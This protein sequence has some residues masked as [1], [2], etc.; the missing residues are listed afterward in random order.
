LVKNG[1]RGSSPNCI[2]SQYIV[3]VSQFSANHGS[4]RPVERLLTPLRRF[5]HVES[6]SSG[7][8]LVCTVVALVIANSPWADVYRKFWQTH[9][10][11][12]IGSFVLDRSLDFWINDGLM[13]VF[14]FVVGL[15]IKREIVG[16]ELNEWRKASLPVLGAIGGMVVPAL[17]YFVMHRSGPAQR[18]WAIPMATDIAFVVGILALLGSRVPAGLKV[19]LLALAIA[20]DIG[21]VLVIALAYTD[22]L[23]M[24]WFFAG[25]AGLVVVYGMKRMGVRSTAWYFVVGIGVWLAFHL[26]DV[27]P[28]VAGVILGLLAPSR[29]LINLPTI[30]ASLDRSATHLRDDQLVDSGEQLAV[31]EEIAWTAKEAVSPLARLEHG[32]HP[33]VSFI[34]MPVFALANAGV[35]ID[36]GR[37]S[38]PVSLAI[39]AGLLIG[40]PLGIVAMC[41]VSVKL[42]LSA[43]PEGTNWKQVVA[44]GFLGGIGFTMAI[45]IAEL[46]FPENEVPDLLAA[47]KVGILTGSLLSAIIGA[48]LLAWATKSP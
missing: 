22:H 28:T 37:L 40:K 17:I 46:A 6:A 13:V 35:A 47:A 27:H 29:P 44:V 48:G 14:F 38:H 23:A 9:L 7:V 20:D 11:I 33:I 31:L 18:G 21:A 1:S 43:L 34:I 12:G 26:A 41:N 2:D 39:A 10:F 32:L 45:F 15:E 19:F 30:R 25:L 36:L 3:A 24:N 16:G 8:L 4:A 42:H 5:L